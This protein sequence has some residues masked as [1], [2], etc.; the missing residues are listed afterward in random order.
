M[1][2]RRARPRRCDFWPPPP[3]GGGWGEGEMSA[4]HY[5]GMDLG[6]FKTSVASSRGIRDVIPSAVG[7]PKDHIARTMLGR[8]VIFGKDVIEQRMALR[9]V[10]PFEKGALKYAT[11]SQTGLKADQVSVGKEAA[12]LL[13]EH[14]VSLTKPPSDC[15]IYGVIGAPSRAT[16]KNKSV[17]LESAKTAFA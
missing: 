17:L 15:Q 12:R 4:I 9:V 11:P 2:R 13:V 7:W 6:T 16:V 3:D 1:R 5:I 8:D 10:R 14:A